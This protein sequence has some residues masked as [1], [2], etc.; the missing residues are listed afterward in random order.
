MTTTTTKQNKNKKLLGY[1]LL[2]GYY[3][4]SNCSL[5]EQL[6]NNNNKKIN[7]VPFQ[8]LHESTCAV[9]FVFRLMQLQSFVSEA[10]WKKYIYIYLVWNTWDSR[11][12]AQQRESLRTNGCASSIKWICYPWT[13]MLYI[14]AQHSLWDVKH[15]RV[16]NGCCEWSVLR[17]RCSRLDVSV[18]AAVQ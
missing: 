4:Q 18:S 6:F 10:M 12:R 8:Y 17:S 5:R 9:G 1:S 14:H 7:K 16:G 3:L 15:V 11:L 2:L 13:E